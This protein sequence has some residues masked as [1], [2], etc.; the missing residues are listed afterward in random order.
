MESNL[1]WQKQRWGHTSWKGGTHQQKHRWNTAK[2]VWHSHIHTVRESIFKKKER[3]KEIAFCACIWFKTEAGWTH[4]GYTMLGVALSLVP[5]K[6]ITQLVLMLL[7]YQGMECRAKE[8]EIG[9]WEEEGTWTERQDFG[10]CTLRPVAA[11]QTD[12]AAHNQSFLFLFRLN[13]QADRLHTAHWYCNSE[14]F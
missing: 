14:L 4:C 11:L 9:W 3:K 8:E 1:G 7:C 2:E 5:S 6:F 10:K 13:P 12:R